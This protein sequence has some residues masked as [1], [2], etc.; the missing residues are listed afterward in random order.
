MILKV[1]SNQ[2]DCMILWDVSLWGIQLLWCK[3]ERIV[4]LPCP[5]FSDQSPKCGGVT[6]VKVQHVL[7]TECIQLSRVGCLE[8]QAPISGAETVQ[9]L[10]PLQKRFKPTPLPPQK[11]PQQKPK[12]MHLRYY[13]P[14]WYANVPVGDLADEML[15]MNSL[16]R[17]AW[18]TGLILTAALKWFL[19]AM[20]SLCQNKK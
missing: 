9:F 2:N 14:K 16:A 20:D 19:Q 4:A 6:F 8:R 17:I 10:P 5:H 3:G 12:P 15:F 1:S 13:S 7:M 18:K 11:K